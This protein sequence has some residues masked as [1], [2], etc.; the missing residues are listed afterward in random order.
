MTPVGERLEHAIESR[1]EIA[2]ELEHAEAQPSSAR[3]LG[4]TIFWL[5]ITGISL[6]LVAPSLIETFGSWNELNKLSPAWLVA[7]AVLQALSLACVWAL[8]RLALHRPAWPPVLHSQLA[9]KALA[10][11]APGGGGVGG[12]LQDRRVR[13]G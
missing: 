5:T 8:Q 1:T 3:K 10:K 12:G 6:Y 2:K 4:K 13:G 9:G 11:G 7:M